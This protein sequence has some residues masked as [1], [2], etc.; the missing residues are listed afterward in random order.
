MASQTLSPSVEIERVRATLVER[1][2][3]NEALQRVN[4]EL[5][6]QNKELREQLTL[7]RRE[8]ER[9]LRGRGGAHLIDEGQG[10]LFS[11]DLPTI[12]EVEPAAKHA[13]EAP[14]GETPDDPIKK[15]HKPKQRARKVDSSALPRRQVMHE[16]PESE[17]FCPTTG[18]PLVPIGEKVFEELDYTPAQLTVIE[19][20]QVKYG[21]APEVAVERQ[22]EAIVTPMPPRALENCAASA[23]FLAQILIQKYEFHLPLYRQEEVFQQAGLWIPRQTLCDWVLKCALVLLR[24]IA[25][26]L[27]RQIGAGPVMGLDDTRLKCRGKKGSGYFQAYLWTFVNPDVLGAVYRFTPGRSAEQLQP[28]LEGVAARYLIGDAYAGNIAA[29]REAGLDVVHGGCWAH[30]LR[31]FREAEKEGGQFARLFVSDIG[32]LYAIERDADKAKVDALARLEAR[33]ARGRPILARIFG[34][35]LAWKEAF[36]S[37]GKMGKAIKYLRNSRE[38][39]KCFLLDGRVPLDNNACENAIRPVAIGRKNFL[40]AGSERGGEAAAIVYSVIESCRR[41][42]VDRWEY[43]S[44]VLVRVATHPASKIAD[45]LP[46]RWAEIRATEAQD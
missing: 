44:D 42:D 32:E 13:N 30:V 14:D 37:S 31:Y 3:K 2:A 21:P 11:T 46:A 34:R 12:A 9:L 1:D 33:R 20:H 5:R 7:L 15:R 24:P 16:L 26:E 17:R 38:A 22:I 4:A 19:H 6:K 25:D 43:L 39:L 8:V 29:A 36:S 18:V 23:G 10:T 45:L 27:M 41:A 35:T 40:F 28:H